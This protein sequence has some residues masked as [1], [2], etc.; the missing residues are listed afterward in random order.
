VIAALAA[1]DGLDPEARAF[2]VR[3]LTALLD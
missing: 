1:L 3:E 2:L